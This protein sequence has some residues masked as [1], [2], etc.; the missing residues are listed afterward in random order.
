MIKRMQDKTANPPYMA[1]LPQKKNY[2]KYFISSV[3]FYVFTLMTTSS[4]A[5]GVNAEH[6]VMMKTHGTSFAAPAPSK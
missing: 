3:S 5:V 4:W 2:L 1:P 6:S